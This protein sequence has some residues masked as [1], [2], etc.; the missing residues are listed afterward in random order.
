MA[1]KSKRKKSTRQTK[2]TAPEQSFLGDEI[3]IWLTLA[4]SILLLISNFGLGGKAGAFAASVLMD[5][6]GWVAY[7]VPFILFGAVAF[8]ISN[9]GNLT[10]YVKTA[11]GCILTVLVCTFFE[12]VCEEGGFLGSL[13]TRLL[14]PAIG[15]IGTYVVVIFSMIICLIIVTGKSALKGVKKHG[16]KAYRRL[17]ESGKRSRAKERRGVNVI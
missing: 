15:V 3:F 9:K 1:S 16:G 17:Q 2:K 6:F 7:M 10:A 4:V 12:L 14:V 13:V 11:A 5:I 8:I